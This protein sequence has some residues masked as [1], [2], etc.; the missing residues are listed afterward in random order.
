MKQIKFAHS[1]SL[2]LLFALLLP[3]TVFAWG[4]HKFIAQKSPLKSYHII[5]DLI[6]DNKIDFC[7]VDDQPHDKKFDEDSVKLQVKAA[8]QL[9]ITPLKGLM[10]QEVEFN[11]VACSSSALDLKI[12]FKDL[13]APNDTSGGS[14]IF[15][16]DD[17]D[18]GRKTQF[19]IVLINI[20][21]PRPNGFAEVVYQDTLSLLKNMGSPE[22]VLNN[23]LVNKS[24]LEEIAQKYNVQT[25]DL[26]YSTLRVL[27]HELGHAFGLCDLY[28]PA[29]DR[30]CDPQFL[31]KDPQQAVML[32]ADRFGLYPDDI[33]GIRALWNRFNRL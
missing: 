11:K 29:K 14:G 27:T 32:S 1:Y 15:Y 18:W 3:K 9:W 10:S 26:Y 12:H 17:T 30:F 6:E 16:S 4:H 7:T 2:L 19:M 28:Q 23:I 25:K 31:T 24:S 22:N 8:L 5:F 13:N 20:G 33:A 21:Q